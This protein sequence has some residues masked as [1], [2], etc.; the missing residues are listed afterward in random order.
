MGFVTIW[1][2]TLKVSGKHAN[3]FIVSL[4]QNGAY[5]NIVYY[6]T[7]DGGNT[8]ALNTIALSSLGLASSS[9]YVQGIGFVSPSEGWIGGTSGIPFENSFL[10][11]ADGG[12]QLVKKWLRQ[13]L[14]HQSNSVS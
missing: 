4:Q 10:Y 1:C 12:I 5:S 8:W 7:T 9:F 14:S 3:W 2:A 11:T 6:K 13:H